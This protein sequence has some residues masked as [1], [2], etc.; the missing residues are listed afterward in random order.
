MDDEHPPQF[1]PGEIMVAPGHTYLVEKILGAGGMGTVYGA[2]DRDTLGEVAIKVLHPEHA[3]ER[4]SIYRRFCQEARIPGQIAKRIKNRSTT[5][6]DKYLLK[7]LAIGELEPLASPY[8][9]MTRLSG[10]PLGKLITVTNAAAR[11]QGRKPGLPIDAALNAAIGL[12]FSLEAL[13]LCGVVHRDIKPDNIFLHESR[14][15]KTS[16]ILL[17]Y[18]VAH[19]MDA[20][21]RV[22]VAGTVGYIAPENL[23]GEIGPPT[24]IF[25]VGV[26]LFYMLGGVKPSRFFNA[27]WPEGGETRE[28]PSLG[29][30]GDFPPALTTLVARCLALDPEARP[31]AVE[32]YTRLLEI[33]NALPAV[34]VATAATEEDPVERSPREVTSTGISLAD[35][36]PP[37]SP[38]LA[39]TPRMQALRREAERRSSLGLPVNSKNHDTTPMRGRPVNGRET[40]RMVLPAAGAIGAAPMGAP[41]GAAGAL[42]SEATLPPSSARLSGQPVGPVSGPAYVDSLRPVPVARGAAALPDQELLREAL[43]RSRPPLD[44]A[45]ARERFDAETGALMESLIPFSRVRTAP[46]ERGALS[47]AQTDENEVPKRH[48][49]SPRGARVVTKR[50]QLIVFAAALGGFVVIAALILLL[51]PKTKPLGPAAIP[52]VESAR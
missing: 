22:G 13:H 9:A 52:S 37:T 21:S 19:L 51:A 25:A 33:S 23:A 18:G 28:A 32:L 50:D 10:R 35:V 41:Q 36:S 46:V 2:I 1:L 11:R 14:D 42:G 17:D 7:V 31:S 45:A 48:A 24:D 29:V 20:G 43:D 16:I 44:A 26:L 27:S 6:A 49:R 8:F 47:R 15:E 12:L 4:G 5:A 30:L 39:L 34:D 40:V 38:D 3:R